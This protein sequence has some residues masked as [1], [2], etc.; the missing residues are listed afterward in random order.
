MKATILKNGFLKITADNEERAEL[1]YQYQQGGY[2]RAEDFV[3][4]TLALIG[5]DFVRPEW[6]A[7]LTD[8]PIITDDLEMNEANE[9]VRVGDTWWFPDYQVMDP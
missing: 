1:K 2:P 7:A 4:E 3:I 5:F 8:A 6:I 9:C